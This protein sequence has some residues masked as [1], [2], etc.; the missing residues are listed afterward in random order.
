MIEQGRIA[1]AAF[2]VVN[3]TIDNVT[4]IVIFSYYKPNTCR[5]TT[6]EQRDIVPL[7]CYMLSRL[8]MGA[9]C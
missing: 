2:D 4:T 8:F 1:E 5:E 3:G 9:C 6:K 7:T